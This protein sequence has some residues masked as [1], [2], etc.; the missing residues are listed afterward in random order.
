MFGLF[1][2]TAIVAVPC[3]FQCGGGTYSPRDS[4]SCRI[5]NF[6]SGYKVR[7]YEKIMFVVCAV[8]STT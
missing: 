3:Y 5:K 6:D 7:V 1:S 8:Q 4:D 2:P